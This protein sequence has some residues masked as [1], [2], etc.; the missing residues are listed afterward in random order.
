LLWD[1]FFLEIIKWRFV[2]KVVKA[3]DE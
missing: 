2:K 1:K 3:I